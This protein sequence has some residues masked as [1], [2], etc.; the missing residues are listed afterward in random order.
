MM[1]SSLDVEK[2][3]PASGAI[4]RTSPS[5]ERSFEFLCRRDYS[6][7]AAFGVAGLIVYAFARCVIVSASK[8]LWFD[9]IGTWVV[10]RQPTLFSMWSAL[11]SGADGNPPALHVIERLTSHF[12]ANQEIA[13]RLPSILGYCI[14]L[15]CI[16]IF[17]RRR[18]DGLVALFCAY[19][20]LGTSLAGYAMEGRPYSLVVSCI[21]L[22]LVCYQ[23]APAT[24]WMF[25]M[26]LS[27]MFAE[28]LHYYA[29]FALFP[30][31]LAEGVVFLQTRTVRL[32][33]W[34]AFAATLVPFVVFWPLMN[35]FKHIYG[36]HFWNKPT[37]YHA[38]QTYP[39]FLKVGALD[40]GWAIIAVF[41]FGILTVMIDRKSA[42]Q[43][44]A[45]LDPTL[46]Q[47][48]ALVFGFLSLPFIAFAVTKLGHGGMVNRYVL[49][50]MLAFPIGFAR[51][52]PRMG[53][54]NLALLVAFVSVVIGYQEL[55][56]WSRRT[57]KFVSPASSI[58]KSVAA[59]PYPDLP[60][61]MTGQLEYL[62]IAHY[63]PP[64]WNRRFVFLLDD[65]QT[66]AH[67]GQDSGVIQIRILSHYTPLHITG[68]ADLVNKYPRFL[69]YSHHANGS[70][71]WPVTLL[72][73]GY[74]LQV[75]TD[76]SSGELYL[77]TRRSFS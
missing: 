55:S 2:Q 23:K 26:A 3:P 69:F 42:N 14:T 39:V 12:I 61:I 36:A 46:W 9:E 57:G 60:V 45:T 68:F 62:E 51:I 53:R 76:D 58:E 54:R 72:Q 52:I 24:R 17:V 71:W 20:T 8:P 43:A 70:D 25:L 74:S 21:A 41:A 37:F 13:F 56:M 67:V 49:Y 33:A 65:Q 15:L 73:E 44:S 47:D 63:A 64:E 18:S 7:Q 30:F 59:T 28:S 40:W 1:A 66:I 19:A 6:K 27:L 38:L 75:L 29:F 16:F 50:G 48:C 11:K 22:A 35:G 32:A 77:V 4:S 10:A 34:L 31:A 5:A